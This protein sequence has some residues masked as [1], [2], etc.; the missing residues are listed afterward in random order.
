MSLFIDVSMLL[1]RLQTPGAQ[2]RPPAQADRLQAL[3]NL[4][5][6]QT[7]RTRPD[8]HDDVCIDTLRDRP[9]RRKVTARHDPRERLT[10]LC[11]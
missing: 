5:S 1:Q 4:F 7:R 9:T 8:G 10:C 6:S 3:L 2:Q 11:T